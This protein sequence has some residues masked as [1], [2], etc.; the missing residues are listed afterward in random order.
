MDCYKDF[1]QN[2]QD[3]AWN[4]PRHPRTDDMLQNRTSP[5]SKPDI[6]RNDCEDDE[7][8]QSEESDQGVEGEDLEALL[9]SI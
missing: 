7:S 3:S 5:Y 8:A 4:F 6:E 9:N 2:V 1:L